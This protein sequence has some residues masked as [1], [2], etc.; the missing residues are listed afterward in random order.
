MGFFLGF[1]TGFVAAGVGLFYA[2][3]EL[4]QFSVFR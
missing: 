3:R 2:L 4:E 1:I